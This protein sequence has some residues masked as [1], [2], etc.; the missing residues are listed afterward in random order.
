M[1]IPHTS[2]LSYTDFH[3]FSPLLPNPGE[4]P[5]AVHRIINEVSVAFFDQ[6]L[7]GIRHNAMDELAKKYPISSSFKIEA[8]FLCLWISS[9][10]RYDSNRIRFVCAS[11]RGRAMSLLKEKYC[12]RLFVPLPKRISSDFDSRYRG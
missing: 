5:E 1:T 9:A 11:L 7:K 2:H 8:P 10:K 12:N 3:L 6:H 4:D